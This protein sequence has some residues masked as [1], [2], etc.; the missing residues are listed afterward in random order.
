MSFNLGDAA[1]NLVLG[2]TAGFEGAVKS[3]SEKAADQA[4]QSAGQ[5]LQNSLAKVLTPTKIG[6]GIGVL[7]AGATEAASKFEDQLRTI[8]T[9]AH[10]SD[11]ELAGVGDSIKQ[12]SS[13]T[14]R[15]L[16]DL[17]GGFYDLVSAGIPADKAMETLS[18]SAKLA[19]GNLG[20]T[21]E[22]VDIVTTALNAFKIDATQSAHVADVFAQAVADGKTTVAGLSEGISRVAP[23]AANAGISLEEVAAATARMTLNGASAS[24][25]YTFMAGSINALLTPNAELNA[26]QKQTGKNFA[27]IAKQKGL[28]VALDELRKSVNGDTEAFAKALGSSEALT[29][30]LSVTGDNAGAMAAELDKVKHSSDNGGTSLQQYAE[31]MKSPIEQGRKLVANLQNIII[32]VGAPFVSTLG[33]AIFAVNQLGA[34]FGAGGIAS[35]VFGGAIGALV[36]RITG[37]LIPALSGALKN[38]LGVAATSAGESAAA[39]GA[40]LATKFVT[41]IQIPL[42]NALFKLVPGLFND[43]GE[44]AAGQFAKSFLKNSALGR[45]ATAAAGIIGPIAIGVTI[46]VIGA[47]IIQGVRDQVQKELH[48]ALSEGTQEALDKA[49]ADVDAQIRGARAGHQGQEWIDALTATRGEITSAM[50]DKARTLETQE[51]VAGAQAAGAFADGLQSPEA[52][53]AAAFAGAHIGEAAVQG[54]A[55]GIKADAPKVVTAF[56]QM[57]AKVQAAVAKTIPSVF[58]AAGR[59]AMTSVAQGI[60]DARQEPLDAFNTL[61]DMLKNA[62]SPVGERAR[63]LGE[64]ASSE[65]A[66]GLKSKDPAVRAQAI[67]TRE[68]ILNRLEE[69]KTGSKNIGKDGMEALKRA[70]K[71]K[72]STIRNAARA[73]Y[74]GIYAKLH[75]LVLDGYTWGKNMAANLAKGIHSQYYEVGRRAGE[76]ADVI[77]QHIRT[78]SPAKTGPLSEGGGPEGWGEHMVSL[79]AKGTKEGE[80]QARAA[81]RA[82]AQTVEQ[83]IRRAQAAVGA[84]LTGS[85]DFL[86]AQ[87]GHMYHTLPVGAPRPIT[88]A[89]GG[90]H[91]LTPSQSLSIGE[92]HLHGVDTSQPGASKKF[93]EDF[94]HQVAKG[95]RQEG[96]RLGIHPARP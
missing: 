75:P 93:A 64:L 85:Y 92:L 9:V 94:M 20:S 16:D 3:A 12:L 1:V 41:G 29:F 71:S 8:N 63:L 35:K 57:N 27:D 38:S 51:N 37:N 74:N 68:L 39:G 25:A 50:Q 87:P 70:M 81:I 2:P 7:F 42:E 56:D 47:N 61:K 79:F 6:A 83:V 23:I 11:S 78:R 54:T 44:L 59:L 88:G 82:I 73:I 58:T 32:T 89:V 53:A 46:A 84:G 77:A 60:L 55:D 67:A 86:G 76:L 66:K 95:F 4:G 80:P 33:P 48:D 18:A 26:I 17:T 5:R 52:K 15:S 45:L 62:M 19:V 21:G 30:A 90:V 65:L 36:G 28:A 14:G 49:L 72:D 24:Q 34:A 22:A 43:A 69:L 31:K 10:L 40:K 13:E 96:A 91:A